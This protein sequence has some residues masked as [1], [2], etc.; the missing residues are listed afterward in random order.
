MQNLIVRLSEKG[1]TPAFAPHITLLGQLTQ[2]VDS[3]KHKL[4]N[5]TQKVQSFQLSLSHLGMYD[6]Y[7][8]SVVV[9]THP[10][11]VLDLLHRGAIEHFEVRTNN[12]FV[13]HLSL[14]YSH[15]R[16]RDKKLLMEGFVVGT[17]IRVNIKELV[18]VKTD[19]GPDQWQEVLRLPLT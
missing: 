19:G 12:T 18:L 8:R 11:S 10:S 2:N 15:L 17:P 7:F 14:L 13:P 1:E 5:F 3:L 9:H 16:M 6:K 4:I